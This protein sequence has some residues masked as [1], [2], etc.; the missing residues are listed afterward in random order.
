MDEIK[1]EEEEM[2]GKIGSLKEA[3]EVDRLELNRVS[4]VVT[5]YES[6]RGE[7]RSLL[8]KSI[9]MSHRVAFKE[10]CEK[11]KKLT[12]IENEFLKASIQKMLNEALTP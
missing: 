11:M 9:E 3:R 2:W 1:R 7:I 10:D 5:L 4:K 12:K 8:E 6:E